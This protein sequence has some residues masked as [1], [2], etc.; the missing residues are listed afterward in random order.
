[1]NRNELTTAGYKFFEDHFKKSNGGYQKRIRSDTGT[2]YFINV[3]F[4]DFS[5]F[6]KMPYLEG[7]S[8]ELQ[9]Y[10]K[11]EHINL[12]FNC[13]E[14]TIEQLESKAEWLFTTLGAEDYE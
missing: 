13:R 9:F 10:V 14:L 12:E 6:N 5:Q 2:R 4:Y 11:D 8:C 3:Y 1:M 7:Y